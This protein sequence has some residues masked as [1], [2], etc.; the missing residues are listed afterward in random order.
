ME[1]INVLLIV[2]DRLRGELK[3]HIEREDPAFYQYAISE[4][5]ILEWAIK[6]GTGLHQGSV[7]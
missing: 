3:H 1:V 7:H 5:D 4:L 6:S 2:I